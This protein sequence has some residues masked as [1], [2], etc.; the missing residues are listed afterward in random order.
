MKWC[1]PEEHSTQVDPRFG[2]AQ[3]EIF[4]VW[5]MV[6]PVSAVPGGAQ[7][8]PQGRQ[9]CILSARWVLRWG[10]GR[11][12]RSVF[13]VRSVFGARSVY[14]LVFGVRSMFSVCALGVRRS[15]EYFIKKRITKP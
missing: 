10:L 15:Q 1:A 12:A 4:G 6:R 9:R 7:V 2:A 3:P 11:S 13:G 8:Q 14:C 5:V